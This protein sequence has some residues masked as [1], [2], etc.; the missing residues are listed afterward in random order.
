MLND[1]FFPSKV[2]EDNP[3][4]L[5][6]ANQPTPYCPPRRSLAPESRENTRHRVG[7]RRQGPAAERQMEHRDHSVPIEWMA[8]F[9]SRYFDEE[10]HF[11]HHKFKWDLLVTID[12]KLQAIFDQGRNPK[13]IQS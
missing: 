7:G 13:V 2:V 6:R 4:S 3:C 11:L 5:K 10:D 8:D 12:E 9:N 1:N